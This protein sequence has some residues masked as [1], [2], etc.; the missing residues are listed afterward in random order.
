[1]TV[2]VNNLKRKQFQCEGDDSV[3]NN[4]EVTPDGKNKICIRI[5]NPWAGDTKP[6][7]GKRHISTFRMQMPWLW[8]SSFL[9][10]QINPN[11]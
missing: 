3:G 1:M 8:Q 6:D 7:S 4:L 9:R 11:P 10:L 2:T 5:E